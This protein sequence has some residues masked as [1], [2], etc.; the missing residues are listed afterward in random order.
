MYNPL[1]DV[2]VCV[3]NCGS[4]NKASEKLFISVPSVMKKVN[5]LENHLDIQL[6][7][8][9]NQG[10]KLTSAGKIIYDYAKK[11]MQ[12]SKQIIQKAKETQEIKNHT[13]C[14]G[15]SILNPCHPFMKLWNQISDS[16][17]DYNLHIVPFDDN[18]EDILS[19]ISLLGKKFDF[20]VGVCDSK[21]WLNRCNFLPLGTYPHQIAMS[22]QNPLSNKKKLKIT[23]LYGQTI[24]MVKKGDSE[25]VDKIRDEL[26]KYPQIHIVDTPQFYDMEVF[27][28]CVKNNNL[29]ITIS[30]WKD[31]HPLLKT[32]D[33][34]WDHPIPYG[35]LYASKP[36]LDVLKLIHEL[37]KSRQK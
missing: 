33:V 12:E 4:F 3:A 10:L 1:L 5:A 17:P 35:L 9:T 16:F 21:L 24:M 30:C 32:I 6:F 25:A 28:Q 15:S 2:F 27:N 34:N 20:I 31:V 26:E 22:N 18:H 7:D 23:D 14:I 8:R 37:K 29:M 11:C 13:F 36:D 19:Q